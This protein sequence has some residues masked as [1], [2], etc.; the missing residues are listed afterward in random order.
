MEKHDIANKLFE[1]TKQ[2]LLDAVGKLDDTHMSELLKIV[3]AVDQS[4]AQCGKLMVCGNGGSAADAQHIVAELVGRF[5]EERQAF[6]AMALTVNS[7]TMTAVSNDYGFDHAF[8]RQVEGLGG[9]NDVLLVISTSGNSVNCIKAVESARKKGIVCFG[10]LG[11]DGG[12]LMEL[13]DGAVVAPS[14]HTPRIQELHIT[15]GHLLCQ[16]LEQW[17]QDKS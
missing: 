10:F 7:S 15:M 8:A 2:D 17:Q 6:A 4:W 13:L 11:R 3:D 1:Q 16:I 14:D 5:E 12:K 9:E